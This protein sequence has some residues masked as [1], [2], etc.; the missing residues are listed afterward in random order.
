M[1]VIERKFEAKAS[2]SA[3]YKPVE[4]GFLEIQRCYLWLLRFAQ[5]SF[6]GRIF[7]TGDHET[8]T[9]WTKRLDD[10]KIKYVDD[11]RA[12]TFDT[13]SVCSTLQACLR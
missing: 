10:V 8:V 4:H 7:R 5:H 3:L 1:E 2:A 11:M 13:G 9:A 12:V 6:V